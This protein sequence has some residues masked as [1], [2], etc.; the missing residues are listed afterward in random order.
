MG[1]QTMGAVRFE[2]SYSRFVLCVWV[3]TFKPMLPSALRTGPP[4]NSGRT[5]RASAMWL[6]DTPP[7]MVKLPPAY[8]LVPDVASDLT[9]PPPLT[10]AVPEPK[11][12]QVLPSHWAMLLADTPPAVVK[13]PPTYRVSRA[14]AT[15]S[16]VLFIPVPTADHALPFHLAT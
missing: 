14:T 7:A 2:A 4:R 5:R 13:I 8:N 1:C 12:D 11:A 3:P 16:T 10:G 15:A 6:A 9:S